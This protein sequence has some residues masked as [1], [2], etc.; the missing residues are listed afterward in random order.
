[1]NL[2]CK[3]C[4]GL[5]TCYTE[6]NGIL[7]GFSAYVEC[8]RCD[9]KTNIHRAFW[10]SDAADAARREWNSMNKLS[11]YS[12]GDNS[13]DYWIPRQNIA[14]GTIDSANLRWRYECP[15]CG[16]EVRNPER[17]CGSCGKR[18]KVRDE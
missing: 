4:G 14:K 17:Y 1:M 2:K 10:S 6:S 3:Y 16:Y 5:G 11:K 15:R 12:F 13:F 18:L 9:N 8:D 7:L